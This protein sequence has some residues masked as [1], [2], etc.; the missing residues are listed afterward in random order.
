MVQA[1]W[2]QVYDELKKMGH[3]PI[4]SIIEPGRP[5]ALHEDTLVVGFDEQHKF[6]YNRAKEQYREVF[7][8]AIERLLGQRLKLECRL[9]AQPP[10]P[11]Q[12]PTESQRADSTIETHRAIQE[13]VDET[14]QLFEG[15]RE[16]TEE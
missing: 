11:V 9:G 5:V 8:Q 16:I 2:P 4:V 6:H 7:E 15:S 1:R 10:S 13:A 12:E 14:L 3:M